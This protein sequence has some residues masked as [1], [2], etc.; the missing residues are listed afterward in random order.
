MKRSLSRTLYLI[1]LGII[2]VALILL[3]VSLIGSTAS[4]DGSSGSIGNPVLF[5]I[6]LFLMFAAAIPA[7]VA[8]IGALVKMA[9]LSRWGWFVCLFFFSG[10]SMLIY[11]FAGPETPA[12]P[13]GVAYVQQ[14]YA[15][16]QY[17][18]QPYGQPQYPQQPYAQ[19]QYPQQPQQP[20]A[21][22]QYPQQPYGQQQSYDQP[23]QPYGQY[24]EQPP[25]S[26][27]LMLTKRITWS[28]RRI[29]CQQERNE[30]IHLYSFLRAVTSEAF[31]T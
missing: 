28:L 27:W 5:S 10:I 30:Y 3:G 20:Y 31:P 26:P 9:Q 13:Q 17:P 8:W 29:N 2:I 15:Q 4:A 24:P 23:Q 19:P 16:P 25:P 22:P 12:V 21:Q 14:P 1:G 6:A 7:L 11:I 18:Q